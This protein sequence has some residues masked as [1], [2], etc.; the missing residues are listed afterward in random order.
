MSLI[1]HFVLL[2][3]FL[4]VVSCNQKR[5][6]E[7]VV[8]SS[9]PPLSTNLKNNLL[10]KDTIIVYDLEGFSSEG[11]EA[12]VDYKSGYIQS[13]EVSMYGET[14]QAKVHYTFYKDSISVLEKQYR[15][16]KRIEDVKSDDDILLESSVSYSINQSGH[17]LKGDTLAT[18]IAI[19]NGI[20]E[21]IPFVLTE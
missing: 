16:T 19:F 2:F 10:N 9:A 8:D 4:F 20:K 7:F 1:K 21:K 5:N 13:V 17:V 14:G 3:L 6:V 11:T 18:S 12:I 15:Y